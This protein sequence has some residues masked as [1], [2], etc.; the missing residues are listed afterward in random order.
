M[1][2]ALDDLAAR[3]ESQDMMWAIVAIKIQRE[4]GGNLAELLTIVA[5]T[6]N[7]RQ[8]LR[9]EVSALTAEGRIS[10]YV[11]LFLP[12]GVAF[13]MYL[14][15][16]TYLSELWTQNLGIVAVIAAIISMIVGGFWMRKI[17]DI[18]L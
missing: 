13:A 5:D 11:L 16:P 1:D 4:V 9:G 12:F 2:D 7:Q 14:L 15:N 10:A 18:E 6:M 8:R 17:V 3:I